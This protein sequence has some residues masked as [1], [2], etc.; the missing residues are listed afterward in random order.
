MNTRITTIR[1]LTTLTILSI[2]FNQGYL[3]FNTYHYTVQTYLDHLKEDLTAIEEKMLH[4]YSQSLSPE[5][6]EAFDLT[7][8]T[9]LLQA[10]HIPVEELRLSLSDTI[11]WRPQYRQSSHNIHSHLQFVLPYQPLERRIVS[12]TIPVPLYPMLAR[13]SF[14]LIWSFILCLTLSCCLTCHLKALIK[15]KETEE[16]RKMFINTMLHELKR[17]VQSLVMCLSFLKTHVQ[18]R[19]ATPTTE[20]VND[21]MFELEHLSA[22]LEKIRNLARAKESAN[23]LNLTTFDFRKNIEKIV[24]SYDDKVKRKKVR[25]KTIFKSK[26]VL[27]TGDAIHLSNI[28]S[29]LVENAIKYS[30]S[31]VTIK[32][33]CHTDRQ[34]LFLKIADNGYGIPVDEQ[35]K[36]FDQFFRGQNHPSDIPGIGLGLSYVKLMTEAHQGTI[37]LKSRPHIG[38]TF[39]LKIPQSK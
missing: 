16:T 13:M 4:T 1:I 31:D 21:A 3:I 24:R 20:A 39:I 26:E 8:F 30:T 11:V 12:G 10:H 2:F 14:Q 25:I 27:V 23:A 17:P 15:Q 29:N 5:K 36:V 6:T 35:P 22:Y 18:Q 34:G 38:T 32:I 7:Q 33:T 9:T 28:V 19:R 37:T